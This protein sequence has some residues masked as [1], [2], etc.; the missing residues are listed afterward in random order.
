MK[1][2]PSWWLEITVSYSGARTSVENLSGPLYL[3]AQTKWT[4]RIHN[5]A[6]QAK[7]IWGTNILV[8]FFIVSSNHTYLFIFPLSRDL[9]MPRHMHEY[10]GW[11]L[12]ENQGNFSSL[13]FSWGCE[14]AQ[15]LTQMN[16]WKRGILQTPYNFSPD[17]SCNIISIY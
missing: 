6:R 13:H 7:T 4:G 5:T 10:S 11:A 16:E 15:E 9:V 8:W 3:L 12:E 2:V 17:L 14:R 1:Y